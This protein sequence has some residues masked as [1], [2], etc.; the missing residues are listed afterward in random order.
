MGQIRK[1]LQK[2]P[3]LVLCAALLCGTAFADVEGGPFPDVPENA[4]YAEAAAVLADMGIFKGDDQGR[5]NPAQTITRAEAAAVICRLQNVEEAAKQ[6][7]SSAFADVPGSHWAVGYVAKAAQLGII[8]GYGDGRFGPEDPVTYEQMLKMLLNM[9]G[10][11]GLAREYQGMD[12]GWSSGYL[13]VAEDLNLTQDIFFTP[14][15][16]A[17]RSAVALLCYR[18]LHT[19][20]Y[21]KLWGDF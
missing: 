12:D 5:F 9:W 4:D 21:D 20:S 8:G 18:T 2:I 10:Y 19:E 14:S 1:I 7:T 17:P 11:E 6:M 3:A 13:R 15:S 16:A